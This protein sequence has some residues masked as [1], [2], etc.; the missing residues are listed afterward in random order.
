LALTSGDRLGPYEIVAPLGKGGMGEVY[1]ARDVTLGRDVAVKILPERYGADADRVVRFQREAQVLASLNHPHIA[2][3]YGVEQVED[4]AT[5]G[6]PARALVLEL[7][8]GETLADRIRRGRL[9]VADGLLLARQIADAL[10]A[11]HERGIVH[12]D[13]KPA[14]IIV[15]PDGIVKVLDFGLAKITSAESSDTDSSHSPTVTV[16]GTQAGIILGTAAYMSPEQAKGRA[17]DRR[18][19]LWSFGVI[20]FEMLT[21]TRIFEGDDVSTT[22]AQILTKEPDWHRLP[23]DLP[24]SIV[25]LLRRCLEKDRR[26]RLDS[27]AVARMEIDEGLSSPAASGAAPPGLSTRRAAAGAIASAAVVAV[28]TLGV[29]QWLF[30]PAP[31]DPAATS[32]FAITLPPAQRMP[33]ILIDRDLA[34]SADGRHIVY[35]IG[36]STAGGPL[37]LRS[38]GE[39]EA[40]VLPGVVN[41]RAPFFSP[42][43]RWIGFFTSSEQNA[44]LELRKISTA[45]GPPITIARN[46]ATLWPSASWLSDDTIIVADPSGVLRVSAAGGEPTLLAPST[47]ES[48][49]NSAYIAGLPGGRGVLFTTRQQLGSWFSDVGDSQVVALDL[50]SGQFKTLL[51]GGAPSYVSL[52]ADLGYLVYAAGGTLF[53]VRFDLNTLSVLGDPAPLLEQVQTAPGGAVNY[54]IAPNGT[55]VYVPSGA[56]ATRSLVW[57]NR[58]GVE[59][60]TTVPM[61]AYSL[62]RLAPDGAQVALTTLEDRDIWIGDLRRNTLRRLTFGFSEDGWPIWAPDSR[63]IVFNSNREGRLNMYSQPAD[64][65]GPAVRLTSGDNNQFPNSVAPDGRRIL[66][67]E[68]SAS[69]YLDIVLFEANGSRQPSDSAQGAAAMPFVVAWPLVRTRATEYNGIVSPDGRFFAYQSN[70]SGRTEVYVKPFPLASDVRWQVSTAGGSSP[71]WA[72]KSRELYY[73]DLSNAVIAVPFEINGATWRAGTSAKVIDSK[74]AAP[75]DMFNY[76]ISPDGQRFLMFKDT[77]AGDEST[78]ANIVVVL[79][80][81]EEI[82]RRLPAR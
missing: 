37:A 29:T 12:R 68:F 57:V 19:D 53:G 39:L 51:R 46:L 28:L 80:W 77:G 76:D 27:A 55:L 56:A 2:A 14:N 65:S 59:T 25:R 78:G 1:R 9:P 15:T 41:A 32:R 73:R 43:G 10:D 42:D 70:E 82:K 61:R 74:Y 50:K 5:P 3:I 40:R 75:T 60:P 69:M 8:E 58:A 31:Q 72:P 30:Q 24:A 36:G 6:R 47:G 38:L 54:D 52:S 20:L 66:A 11:A 4:P 64:G 63:T 35:R 71:L 79:N 21:A 26:R 18:V 81:A 48:R 17:A 62:M 13:L 44:G 45:G 67:A 22:L 33:A 23:A 49:L 16:H 7:V 34:I